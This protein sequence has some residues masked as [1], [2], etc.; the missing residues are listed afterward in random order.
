VPILVEAIKEQQVIIDA[1]SVQL[2]ELSTLQEKL[3]TMEERMA[4]YESVLSEEF[5][6]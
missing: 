6:R 1:Q 5:T 2:V 3:N 4:K